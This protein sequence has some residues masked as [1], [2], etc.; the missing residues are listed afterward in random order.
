MWLGLT[1]SLEQS[2]ESTHSGAITKTGSALARRL[3][4]QAAWHYRRPP[5]I[6]ATLRNRQ[7]GQATPAGLRPCSACFSCG[8]FSFN[9]PRA[10]CARCWESS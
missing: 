5:R 1:P 9:R 4:V 2:G 10:N 7:A 3:L 8:I 6:G